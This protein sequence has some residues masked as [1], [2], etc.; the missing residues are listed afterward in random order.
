MTEIL[1][2]NEYLFRDDESLSSLS[3]DEDFCTQNYNV[4]K[5]VSCVLTS[6]TYS[7]LEKKP[8]IH[9]YSSKFIT[10]RGYPSTITFAE[11]GCQTFESLPSCYDASSQTDKIVL[12]DA[13]FQIDYPIDTIK[14][15]ITFEKAYL[16]LMKMMSFLNNKKA[17]LIW[18]SNNSKQNMEF[19]VSAYTP[20]II[21]ILAVTMNKKHGCYLLVTESYNK[22]I[23]EE[24][25][26]SNILTPKMTEIEIPYSDNSSVN[27]HSTSDYV[28]IIIK[29]EIIIYELVS[30]IKIMHVKYNKNIIGIS[31][32]NKSFLLA[33]DDGTFYEINDNFKDVKLKF[34]ISS[35]FMKPIACLI[36]EI[37]TID[38][39]TK[40]LTRKNSSSNLKKLIIILFKDIILLTYIE[41]TTFNINNYIKIPLIQKDIIE[42]GRLGKDIN[43]V[44]NSDLTLLLIYYHKNNLAVINDLKPHDKISNEN[45]ICTNQS[46]TIQ[47]SKKEK[48]VDFMFDGEFLYSMT[49]NG[50]ITEWKLLNN[51]RKHRKR[52]FFTSLK[53][54]IKF[55]SI[56][57]GKFIIHT[58]LKISFITIN[59]IDQI[60]Q[61]FDT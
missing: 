48:I 45:K 22:Y 55:L 4:Q 27:L 50:I 46:H 42:D 28:A 41:S 56:N 12:K 49:E 32:L 39:K 1:P 51:G 25:N 6:H 57:N 47:F 23:L 38:I 40:L 11:I 16:R 7:F 30:G 36:K 26:L 19:H 37:N 3:C 20:N 10:K 21:K 43:I 34:I 52:Q 61:N 9:N 5:N 33:V 15:E 24:L 35:L 8:W 14:L 18:Y 60:F 29:K 44:C 54:C 58:A 2:K 59:N 13:N 31:N 53:Y 17:W